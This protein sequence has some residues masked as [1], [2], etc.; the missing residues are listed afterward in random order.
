M[1]DGRSTHR[2]NDYVCDTIFNEKLDFSSPP[3]SSNLPEP[4]VIQFNVDKATQ[5]RID[6]AQKHFD[7]LLGRH[8]LSVQAYQG[9]GKKLIKRFKLSPDAYVQMTIQLAYYKMFGKSKPTYESV[10]TRRFQQGRT[11]ACRSVS[12]DSIAFCRAISDPSSDLFDVIALFRRAVESHVQ[13]LHAAAD[14]KRVDRHSFGLR[15][16]LKAGEGMPAVFSDPAYTYSSTWVLSTSQLSSE[17]LNGFGW[18]Q[19][20]DH[21]FGIAYM[22][23][24]NR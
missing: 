10:M 3:V 11:E 20:V 14:G 7:D 21:G 22:I 12:D 16:L 4:V 23:N 17:Y 1:M 24:E 8:D 9:Y 18:S 13:Y 6:L 19:V 15:K 5:E 2:L